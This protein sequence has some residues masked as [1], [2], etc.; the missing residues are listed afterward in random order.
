MV[1]VVVVHY[2]LHLNIT[3]NLFHVF[4]NYYLL[5]DVDVEMLLVIDYALVIELDTHHVY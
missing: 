5:V 2:E 3:E 1:V 4:L